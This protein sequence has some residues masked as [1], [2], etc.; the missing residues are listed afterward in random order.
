M[1]LHKQS[2][3]NAL[4]S[5]GIKIGCIL[6]VCL[7]TTLGAA[8]PSHGG[9]CRCPQ[10]GCA[11]H[12]KCRCAFC[13]N[14]RTASATDL[15]RSTPKS[16]SKP[17]SN[18]CRSP[19]RLPVPAVFA[20][21]PVSFVILQAHLRAQPAAPRAAVYGPRLQKIRP[22]PSR[23]QLPRIRSGTCGC[24][25]GSEEAFSPGGSKPFLRPPDPTCLQKPA[26]GQIE[27]STDPIWTS[28]SGKRHT[29]PG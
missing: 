2:T 24:G 9:I 21:K 20:S 4:H 14:Q 29:P 12:C 25:C 15:H 5:L 1:R 8:D 11:T 18:C 17:D 27:R 6:L 23:N 10:I 7:V 16:Q 19:K 3:T 26:A 28:Q 13:K 22:A